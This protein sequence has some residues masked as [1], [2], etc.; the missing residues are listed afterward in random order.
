MSANRSAHHHYLLIS[1]LRRSLVTNSEGGGSTTMAQSIISDGPGHISGTSFALVSSKPY[2]IFQIDLNNQISTISRD[3]LRALLT[4]HRHL[5]CCAL[6]LQL[7]CASIIKQSI[8]P[9]KCRNLFKTANALSTV[10]HLQTSFLIRGPVVSDIIAGVWFEKIRLVFIVWSAAI[11]LS[12]VNSNRKPADSQTS[13]AW[14]RLTTLS[15]DFFREIQPIYSN[16]HLSGQWLF[17][18][19]PNLF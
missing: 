9:E 18:F 19:S 11:G 4:E 2:A 7:I 5:E 16:F 14:I 15:D 8:M 13:S 10:L 1:Q 17:P 6:F 12:S 3:S